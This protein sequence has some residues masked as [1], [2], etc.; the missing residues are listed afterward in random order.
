MGA[1]R[2]TGEPGQPPGPDRDTYVPADNVCPSHTDN[3]SPSY[4]VNDDDFAND[5]RSAADGYADEQS[6]ANTFASEFSHHH[7]THWLHQFGNLTVTELTPLGDVRG[8]RPR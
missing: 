6:A 8:G 5:K 7:S 2:S 4:A 3:I 1:T